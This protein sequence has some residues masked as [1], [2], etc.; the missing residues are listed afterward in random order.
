MMMFKRINGDNN[1]NTG[2]RG[3]SIAL[4]NYIDYGYESRI[5]NRK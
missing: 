4:E 2:N 5:H 1:I 3:K